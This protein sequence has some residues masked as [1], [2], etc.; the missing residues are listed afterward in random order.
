MLEFLRFLLTTTLAAS[1]GSP[2][3]LVVENLLLRHHLKVLT[4]PMRSRARGRLRTWDK[5]VW[6]V[7][8]PPLR[9]RRSASSSSSSCIAELERSTILQR[10]LG[11]RER[12]ARDGKFVNGA[13][14]FGFEVDRAG[15]LVPSERVLPGLGMTEADA[16]REM[17]RRVAGGE[18]CY[19]VAEWLSAAGVPSV[20][21]LHNKEHH[22]TI[23]VTRDSRV[24]S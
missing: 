9:C 23:D 10:T 4:R 14:P 22:R 17:F 15:L 19:A 16:V 13:V 7:G 12:V 3:D 11:G 1:V 20:R 5:L 2:H 21:R 18:S 8:A 24:G 6:I